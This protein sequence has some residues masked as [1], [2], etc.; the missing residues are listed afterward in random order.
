[1]YPIAFQNIEKKLRKMARC[2]ELTRNKHLKKNKHHKKK[3]ILILLYFGT[4]CQEKNKFCL[5][6][7]IFGV[8]KAEL[9]CGVGLKP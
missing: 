1:M 2:G 5:I 8:F 4:I 6:L 7:A 3:V 9:L